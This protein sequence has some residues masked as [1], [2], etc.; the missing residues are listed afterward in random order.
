M[1]TCPFCAEEIQDAAIKC[2]FCG[3]DLLHETNAS[4]ATAPLI[5]VPDERVYFSEGGIVITS[6]R[7]VLRER[8]FAMANITSV[9]LAESNQGA[10]CGCTLL[11]T[12]GLFAL[13]LFGSGTVGLGVFGIF[14]LIVGVA[15]MSQKTY[16]VR[17]GS[18]SGETNALQS[19]SRE[20]IQRIVGALNQAIIDRR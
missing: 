13:G 11:G 8:T 12:G 9:S 10:G 5:S 1:K 15:L 14:L 6:T 18:A 16:V 2:R 17:I 3:S 7:A 20:Y 19:S 4:P